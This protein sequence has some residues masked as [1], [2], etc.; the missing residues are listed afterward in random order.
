[1]GSPAFA[2]TLL[3]PIVA[4][5]EFWT[6]NRRFGLK[7]PGCV[8]ESVLAHC[9]GAGDIETGGILIGEYNGQHDCAVVHQVTGPPADSAATRVRFRRGIAGLQQLLDRLWRRD[10]RY[11]L[12]E[13]HFHPGAAPEPS[14]VDDR[15]LVAIAQDRKYNCPEPALLIIGGDPCAAWTA[16]AFVFPSGANRLRMEGGKESE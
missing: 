3:R 5:L 4:D 6:T 8:L 10:G 15:Q 7:V 9:R 1:M 16:A 12:G 14:G 2:S 13:W 11:Y